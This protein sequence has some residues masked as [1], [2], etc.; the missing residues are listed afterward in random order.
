[1]KA[2][3]AIRHIL[4]E[5]SCIASVPGVWLGKTGEA[6]CDLCQQIV[7]CIDR[8]LCNAQK[9]RKDRSVKGSLYAMMPRTLTTWRLNSKDIAAGSFLKAIL[10]LPQLKKMGVEI[11]YLLPVF[12]NSDLHKKGELGSPYAIKDFYTLDPLLHDALLGEYSREMLE[13]AFEAFVEAAHALGMKVMLDV[14]FRT[15]ARDND[16]LTQKPHWFYWVKVQQSNRPIPRAGLPD[17]TQISDETLNKVYTDKGMKEY[18]EK[19]VNAPEPD[20]QWRECARKG[21]AQIEKTYGI[22]TAPAFSDVINDVQPLWSDVTYLRY[23]LGMSETARRHVAQTQAPF[24]MYD[25]IKLD[26]YAAQTPNV[27]LWEYILGILPHYIRTFDIDGARIDM[28]HALPDELNRKIVAAARQ[29]KPDFLLWSEVLDYKGSGKA[30]QEGFDFISGATW[31]GYR[32]PPDELAK[33]LFSSLSQSELPIACALETPDTNRLAAVAPREKVKMLTALNLLL[34]NTLPM[35]TNGCEVLEKQPINLG[36]CESG[37]DCYVLDFNDEMR[38]KLAFFDRYQLHWTQDS[39]APWIARF[40]RLRSRHYELI[41]KENMTLQY[42]DGMLAIR[43]HLGSHDLRLA[44]NLTEEKKDTFLFESGEE[45]E[46]GK[47]SS[48]EKPGG[49]VGCQLSPYG[50]FCAYCESMEV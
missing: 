50:V 10:Y 45:G 18:L 6:E 14:V 33:E 11:V 4:K 28:G 20:D 31:A 30:K 22:T 19:F 27:E 16:L 46:W 39:I 12:Q 36:L 29:C 32:L 38:G 47:L 34:P 43:Y 26:R 23:D 48:S 24:I 2:L 17:M 1:M 42:K 3:R 21:L 9:P 5:K 13:L 41:R 7:K 25:T 15:V 40:A 44:F 37:Q 35:H 8:I 49:A